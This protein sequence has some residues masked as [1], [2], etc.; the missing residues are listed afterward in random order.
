MSNSLWIWHIVCSFII[1]KHRLVWKWWPPSWIE[2]RHRRPHCVWKYRSNLTWPYH[3]NQ[4]CSEQLLAISRYNRA[5]L[6]SAACRSRSILRLLVATGGRGPT[7]LMEPWRTFSNC[8]SSSMLY[9]RMN[10]PILVTRGSSWM[11]SRHDPTVSVSRKLS[12]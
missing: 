5:W 9:L 12:P 2:C 7:K 8:G 6:L 3:Q 11:G 10:F 1:N 4:H